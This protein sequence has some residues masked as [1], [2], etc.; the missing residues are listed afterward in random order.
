MLQWRTIENVRDNLTGTNLNELYNG[1][2]ARQF[3]GD[4][5]KR[6]LSEMD[7]NK[8]TGSNGINPGF[9][10]HFWEEY[11]RGLIEEGQ[12]DNLKEIQIITTGQKETELIKK[13]KSP[14]FTNIRLKDYV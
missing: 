4:E 14:C 9:F 13:Q 11:V 7:L 1:E 2:R 10:Q 12:L 3:N 5:F 8:S 6:A